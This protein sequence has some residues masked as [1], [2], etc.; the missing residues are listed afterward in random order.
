MA[1]V[2]A[3]ENILVPGDPSIQPYLK[4]PEVCAL[5]TMSSITEQAYVMPQEYSSDTD[6]FQADLDYEPSL[7]S[8][9]EVIYDSHR[10]NHLL[11][12]LESKNWKLTNFQRKKAEEMIGKRQKAFNLPLEPLPKTHLVEHR[13]QLK[14]PNKIIHVRPRWVPIHQRPH[15]E[16]ELQGMLD[17]GLAVPTSSPH[18]SPIVLVRKKGNKWRLATDFRV[19]N[20]ESLGVYWPMPNVEEVLL[21]IANSKIHSRMDMKNGFM[22]IGL[23]KMSQPISAFSC[24][25]GHYM[26]TRLPFGL[27]S[28]PHTLNRLMDLV[29]KDLSDSVSTFFDDI[30]CHSGSVEQHIHDL[31]QALAALIEANLQVSPEKSKLFTQQ[32][33]DLGHIA[34]GG[35]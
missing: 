29:F 14:D 23:D 17:H 33:E 32:V 4:I 18:N 19:A 24:H 27:A 12:M 7:L 10:A 5:M 25:K 20:A 6:E 31:D 16:N 34:G 2:I 26:Y 3:E 11:Q 13:I 8:K 15:V 28:G 1:E 30:F 22:Q 9:E 35:V 21:R